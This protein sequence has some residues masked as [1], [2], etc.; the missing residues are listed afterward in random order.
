MTRLSP[1]EVP[2]PSTL[3]MC[4]ERRQYNPRA[5]DWNTHKPKESPEDV[6]FALR[7]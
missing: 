3:V 6:R 5:D 7:F 4:V 2:P 1:D